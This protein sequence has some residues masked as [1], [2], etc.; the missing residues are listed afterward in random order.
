[1]KP[2][3]R[4]PL[5]TNEIIGHLLLKIAHEQSM[6][7]LAEKIVSIDK[8]LSDCFQ[9][10]LLEKG[11]R[12]PACPFRNRCPDQ[13][14]CL[15]LVSAAGWSLAGQVSSVG[16]GSNERCL[17]IGEGLIGQAARTSETH[18]LKVDPVSGWTA[19]PG[20]DWLEKEQIRA[21]CAAPIVFK[22][23]V[24]GVVAGF[25]RRGYF[26]GAS[27]WA[28]VIGEHIGAAVANARAFSEIQRLKSLLEVQNTYLQEEMIEAKAF[29]SLIGKS[30]ALRHIVSQIELVAPT[31]ASVL[32]LGETGTGKELVAH[33]IHR[34][35]PRSGAT[36]V[37]VN[38]AGIPRELFESEFFGHVRGA[39]TGAI[40][41]R[42]GRFEAAEN[43][44]LFL[45][46]V[47]DLPL[48]MQGKLLRVLQEKRYERVGETRTRY[49]NVRIIGATNRDL[50]K[51]A[52]EGLF[53]EDLYYRI[54]V[55][56]I[57]VPPLRERRDDIPLL[58]SHFVDLSVREI[59]CP[60]PRL[61][62]AAVAKL[63]EY[64]WPGN[65]RELR[66]V[67]ERAVILARGGALDFDVPTSPLSP[68]G[69]RGIIST[70]EAEAMP[71]VLTQAELDRRERENLLAILRKTDWKIKGPNGAAELL[72]VKSTTLYSRLRRMGIRPT[73]S[74]ERT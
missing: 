71:E 65:V 50:K 18:L 53:R 28:K 70:T 17:P 21:V 3:F 29:G 39:F 67:V 41:E 37:R 66:S 44:T 35:S 64:D 30:A 56:P 57:H 61:T 60:K 73:P 69:S 4:E 1:M 15:H 63:Q 43:G 31:E 13:Q 72:G 22:E 36:M 42:V 46:E 58:A 45:D 11:D 10:W 68:S 32:I 38:C 51:A 40:K 20:I 47:G 59:K 26:K 27:L 23:E 62:R 14:R 6:E 33:E 16:F 2:Q 24:L 12:C 48:D 54:N 34:H 52:A 7:T 5:R 49:A 25:S 19:L 74:G 8:R 55:F 9:I